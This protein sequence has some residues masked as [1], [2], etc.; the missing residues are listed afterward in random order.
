MAY[1]NGNKILFSPTVTMTGQNN[2][3]IIELSNK[4]LVEETEEQTTYSFATN[5]TFAGIDAHLKNNGYAVCYWI[6]SGFIS[7]VTYAPVTG[8]FGADT[9]TFGIGKATL[10]FAKYDTEG[11]EAET[12]TYVVS[13]A[14][15]VTEDRVNEL[16]D[17]SFITAD[18]VDD[19]PTDAPEGTI[20]FVQ[21]ALPDVS[22]E[23]A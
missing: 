18:N 5:K 21:T 22:K 1:I 9:I 3:M 12:L 14:T 17:E 13:K 15:T 7:T 16:I 8:Y 20:A 6:E 11:N 4:T 23:G 10:Y 19:L 2:L